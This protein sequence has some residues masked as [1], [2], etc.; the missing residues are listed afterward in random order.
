MLRRVST[1]RWPQAK[2]ERR[3]L[4]R[5]ASGWVTGKR[6]TISVWARRAMRCSAAARTQRSSS[7]R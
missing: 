2:I 1:Q 3:T 5:S 7:A 4:S 6:W